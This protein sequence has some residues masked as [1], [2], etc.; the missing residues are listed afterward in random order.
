MTARDASFCLAALDDAEIQGST[1]VTSIMCLWSIE[2][3]ESHSLGIEQ[4][5][6]GSRP[7]AH[8][9]M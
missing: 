8:F 9:C 1:T 7:D 2:L 3:Q 5:M 6:L 4:T